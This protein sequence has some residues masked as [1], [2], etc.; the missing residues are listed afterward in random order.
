MQTREKVPG[1][2]ILEHTDNEFYKLLKYSKD[3]HTCI[4]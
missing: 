4:M 3:D 1:K 2:T